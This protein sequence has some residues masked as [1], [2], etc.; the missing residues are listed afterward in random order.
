[1]NPLVSLFVDSHAWNEIYDS[2]AWNEI[3][4]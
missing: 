2:H 3:Y 4:K 1:V